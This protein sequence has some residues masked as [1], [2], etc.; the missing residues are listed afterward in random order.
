MSRHKF[1]C[2]GVTIIDTFQ[3]PK[4]IIPYENHSPKRF[5]RATDPTDLQFEQRPLIVDVPLD[6]AALL[7]EGLH[8][9]PM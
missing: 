1:F 6:V 5:K 8:V 9:L 3:Y 4:H 2:L 7:V